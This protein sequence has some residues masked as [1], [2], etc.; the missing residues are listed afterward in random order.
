MP[1]T[2][3]SPK[4]ARLASPSWL[5]TRLVLGVLLVLVSVVVGARVLSS[6]DRSYRV[7]VATHDIAAGVTLEDD[8]F[9]AE[10]VR[11]DVAQVNRLVPVSAD[12]PP[13]GRTSVRPLTA[14]DLVLRS[15]LE[16]RRNFDLRQFTLNIEPG[17]APPDL[18]D[19][20]QVDV[21]V[22]P[23]ED[24]GAAPTAPSAAPNLSTTGIR[25]VL[26]GIAVESA[27]GGGDSALGGGS[28]AVPVVL[29]LVPRD[30]L[31]MVTAVA[32]GRIDLVRVY[33]K[34]AP[35]LQPTTGGSPAA[36]ATPSPGVSPAGR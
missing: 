32:Q 18:Q 33:G 14:G 7:Y 15:S 31:P 19:G 30:V 28:E 11:L 6:A 20:E 21:Y 25:K 36:S 1:D 17:H 2:P 29:L 27:G 35:P 23:E 9:R 13:V 34:P 4:A 24:G 5:D 10:E 22:T 8:D 3:A 26:S 16:E 12:G